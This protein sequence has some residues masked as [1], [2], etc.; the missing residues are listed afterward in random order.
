MQENI[1]IKFTGDVTEFEPVV[2]TF[3]QLGKISKE[4]ADNLKKEWEKG[5]QAA[6]SG[7]ENMSQNYK[8][9]TD[10]V[11]N[12]A[13]TKT[14]KD[15]ANAAN[16]A[17]QALS[18]TYVDAKVQSI[19]LAKEL[20][21]VETQIE[22]AFPGKVRD[23]LRKEAVQIR[24]RL[25]E[26]N[27]VMEA[28][29]KDMA[30]LDKQIAKAA[31]SP[32]AF[33]TSIRK[34][35]DA[36]AQNG[37]FGETAEQAAEMQQALN[38][39][40]KEVKNLAS[41]TP[42]LDAAMSLGSGI[43]GAFNTATATAALFGGETEALQRAFLRVQAALA[44]LNGV[45]AVSNTLSKS[46]ALLTQ[47]R[48]IQ[49]T[50]L[51]KATDLQ[52]AAT[53]KATIA[54]KAL[55]IVAKVSPWV[56][57]ATAL[58]TVVGALALFAFK[59]SE[60]KKAQAELSKEIEKTTNQ[61]KTLKENSDFDIAMAEAAGKSRAELRQMRIDAAGAQRDI[62]DDMYDMLRLSGKASEEQIKQAKDALDAANANLRAIYRQNQVEIKKEQTDANDKL[63]KEQEDAYEKRLKAAQDFAKA[64]Q[65][66][67]QDIGIFKQQLNA[68]AEK[69]IADDEKKSFEERKIALNAFHD[70]QVK[71]I[72]LSKAKELQTV[73]AGSEQARL[74]ELKYNEQVE[75]S[76][77]DLTAS[78]EAIDK[79]R[80][81]KRKKAVEDG[82]KER[83]LLIEKE[84]NASLNLIDE[85]YTNELVALSDKF[86]QGLINEKQYQE[87]RRQLQVT[88]AQQSIQDE[89][90]TVK[91]KMAVQGLSVSQQED[92]SKELAK[93]ER[94]MATT[95][96]DW[97]IAENER[98]AEARLKKE[99]ELQAALQEL[100][101]AAFDFSAQLIQMNYDAQKAALNQ[102]LA[103][104]DKFYTTDAEAAKKN[105][106]LKLISEE[107]RARREADIKNKQAKLDK[108]NAIAMALMNAAQS[109]IK[110]FAT[111]GPPAS[112]VLAGI[113]AAL[114]AIQIAAIKNQKIPQYAKGRTGG[115]GEYA[116]VGERGPE[117]V[118]LPPKA[119]VYPNG[120]SMRMLK[121][122][123]LPPRQ[124]MQ[125]VQFVSAMQS[126]SALNEH[127]TNAVPAQ[128]SIDY[129]KLGKTIAQNIP[130]MKQLNV[131]LNKH[132][133]VSYV[134]DGVGRRFGANNSARN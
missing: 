22:K 121:G 105:S 111:T 119:D 74:I 12:G 5:A 79:D 126:S 112:F 64:E 16:G 61:L 28:T 26:A 66:A 35:R 50:A 62:A 13:I 85:N 32:Q 93:L 27:E 34:M 77:R 106:N 75:Q 38:L 47:I 39:A 31:E 18:K 123:E 89:I 122:L 68:D 90:D 73:V 113:T 51:K 19:G 88:Y 59:S 129:E 29:A 24:I 115:K 55:N 132:G 44:V 98:S 83:L 124:Q 128:Q 110:V 91:R 120:K 52:T 58:I 43:A 69:R 134:S 96:A 7:I 56:L 118:W 63:L 92:L 11:T 48:A 1:I 104:L 100:G 57:L 94:E 109:I 101:L 116:M 49:T 25:K 131:S 82:A 41:E 33:S 3:V 72:E 15:I 107:E 117:I 53:V 8:K 133:F 102:Q 23:G 17:K 36:L 87:Q 81:E 78:L 10:N 14:F 95:T 99:Q 103:D 30:K 2:D 46:S 76:A 130:E 67:A 108:D 4:T 42:K 40:N 21:E 20:K 60:A 54:Q 45:Q 86:S 97:Q 70:E 6:S 80:E 114:T 125:G 84:G 127:R 37:G 9:L 65:G 71:T